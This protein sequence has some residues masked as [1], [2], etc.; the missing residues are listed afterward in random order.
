MIFIFPLSAM[1]LSLAFLLL[2]A[3]AQTLRQKVFMWQ[4]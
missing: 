2:V 1:S 3:T 4:E